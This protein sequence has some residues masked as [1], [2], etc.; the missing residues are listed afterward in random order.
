MSLAL[1]LSFIQYS[2][3]M[4]FT[5]GPNNMM[6]AASGANFGYWRSLPHILGVTF[7]FPLMFLAVGL[8]FSQIFETYPLFYMTIK[9]LGLIYLV[10]LA[11]KISQFK[12][13][14]VDDK[15]VG[16]IAKPI[17][18]IQAMLFQWIN[19]KAWATMT[20]ALTNFTSP[21]LEWHMGYQVAML[22]GISFFVSYASASSWCLFGAAI[23]PLLKKEKIRKIFNYT[24]AILVIASVLVAM[25]YD[26]A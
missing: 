25:L 7:G 20:I 6:L 12:P 11:Y 15:D 13:K 22:V 23:A 3:V 16:K 10:Y 18:F 26:K 8:G 1:I 9:I 19:P 4:A 5:P 14:K 24:M 21:H 2:L 17:S